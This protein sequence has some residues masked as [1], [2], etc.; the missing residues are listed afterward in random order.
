MKLEDTITK[1]VA[2]TVEQVLESADSHKLSEGKMK[3]LH[4]YIE[5]GLSAEEIIKKMKLKKTP[6]M[7][8][9]I[10]GL[11]KESVVTREAYIPN[12]Y[13]GVEEA[14]EFTK[15]AAQ[16]TVDGKDEF[17]FEG[18]TYKATMKMDAAKKILGIEEA[19][20]PSKFVKGG[21]TKT[22][23]KDVDGML[24]KIFIDTKLA[25]QAEA[26]KAYKAGEK[27]AGKKK[28]PYKK[29][30]ADFHLYVLGTQSAQAS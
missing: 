24:S 19:I 17:E 29:D 7:I 13:L 9:F 25:K 26:S 10:K 2:E 15:A 16:A 5:D 18:K 20:D 30:T 22:T 1:S 11:M 12:K 4:G 3:E 6:D 23:K 8:K 28:N 21:N 14:N 27:D